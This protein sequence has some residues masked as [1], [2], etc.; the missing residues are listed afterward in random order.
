MCHDFFSSFFLGCFGGHKQNQKNNNP[1]QNKENKGE[2]TK[3]RSTTT[4]C[5][6]TTFKDKKKFMTSRKPKRERERYIVH[7]RTCQKKKTKK[8]IVRMQNTPMSM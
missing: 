6:I 4:P 2:Q 1:L 5:I 7:A 3:T 8:T